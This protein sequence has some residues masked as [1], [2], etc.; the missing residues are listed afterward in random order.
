MWTRRT[1]ALA[2]AVA[3]PASLMLAGCKK[4]EPEKPAKP[5][6]PFTLVLN[7]VPEPEFGGFYAGQAAGAYAE[8]GVGLT[9]KPGGPGVPALQMVAAGQAD[10]AITGADELLLAREQ[11]ADVMPVYAVYQHNPQA[12]MTKGDRGVQT[13][14][15]VFAGGTVALEPGLPYAK[16]LKRK[17]TF[18]RVKVVPYDGGIAR[19]GVEE[20]YAQQCYLTSEPLAAKKA[21]LATKVFPISAEG[22]DPYGAV[23]AVKRST[24]EQKKPLVEAFVRATRAGWRAYLT[25]PK[26]A[27][28]AMAALNKAMAP[29]TFAAAAEAQRDLIETEETK[30]KGL[31]TMSEERW[32][33]LRTTLTALDLL[34]K[35]NVFDGWPLD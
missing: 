20:N 10:A 31:G 29:E 33:Q 18:D 2:L 26:P 32:K 12:I 11:G 8:E 22:Y 27:N 9:I 35:P 1:F 13:L 14:G 6:T 23:V 15:D 5:Q 25:N 3:L 21:G 16:F 34:T 4:K 19:L 7:W 28:D 30:A 17:Y 24:W